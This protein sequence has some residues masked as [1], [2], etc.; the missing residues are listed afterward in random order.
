MTDHPL[1]PHFSFY[2]LTVTGNAALQ[3]ANRIDALRYK[4]SLIA[5]AR[6]LERIRRYDPLIVNSAFRSATLNK[7]TPGSSPTSQHPLG[8]AADIRRPNQSPTVLFADL[9][10]LFRDAKIPFGQLILE[11][12]KRDYGVVEWVHVSLGADFWKPERCGEV[13]RKWDDEKGAPRF[14]LVEKIA[15]PPQEATS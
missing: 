3:D 12:A 7:A 1:S 14:E 9:R 11:S 15:Q 13:L 2:E 4:P 6:F 10:A 8:Q 5:L